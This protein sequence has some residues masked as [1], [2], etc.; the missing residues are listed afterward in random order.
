MMTKTTLTFEEID[1]LLKFIDFHT[2]SFS[3]EES[4]QE[5]NEIVG[6][7]VSVLYDKLCEMMDEV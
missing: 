2:E 6:T 3:D 4:E 1:A 5:L 7:N